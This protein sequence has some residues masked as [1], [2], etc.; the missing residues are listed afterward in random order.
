MSA[1][2][3]GVL[4]RLKHVVGTNCD[5]A[6]VTDFHLVVKFDQTLCL[7]PMLRAESSPAKQK[8]HGICPFRS[9]SF[10]RLPV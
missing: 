7:A 10:G 9:E 6:G 4:I 8:D 5:Q 2:A 3:G 1:D